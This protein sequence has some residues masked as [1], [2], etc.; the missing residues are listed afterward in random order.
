M[1]IPI[2][3]PRDRNLLSPAHYGTVHPLE[4]KMTMAAVQLSADVYKTKA[5]RKKLRTLSLNLGEKIPPNNISWH[6]NPNNNSW[7]E[8]DGFFSVIGQVIV[9]IKRLR[10]R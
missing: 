5:F 8:N 6:G 10:I 1:S 3:L 4:K 7:H 2:R 9:L